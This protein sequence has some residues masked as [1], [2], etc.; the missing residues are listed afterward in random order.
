M[1]AWHPSLLQCSFLIWSRSLLQCSFLITSLLQIYEK[2]SPGTL[3]S[4]SAHFLLHHYIFITKMV[5]NVFLAPFPPPVLIFYHIFL[6][7]M[8]RNAMLTPF[9]PPVLISHYTLLQ[10][11]EKCSLG[12]L[13]S[14]SAH[15]LLHPY[16]KMMRNAL[17][18][19][20]PP[21]VFIS[22]YILITH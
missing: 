19:P 2:C 15:F 5:R 11:D 4:S 3:P 20:F 21:P 16:Y 9:P 14:S 17:L 22:Y 8:M 1:L 7:K 13:P 12:T 18:A 6:Y 10:D